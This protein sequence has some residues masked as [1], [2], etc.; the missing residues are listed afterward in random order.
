MNSKQLVNDKAGKPISG[1]ALLEVMIAIVIF[2]IG[3]IALAS[4]QGKLTRYASAAKQRTWAMNIAEDQIENMRAFVSLASI[5]TAACSVDPG[6]YEDLDDCG[7]AV[8]AA[9]GEL[10]YGVTWD[11][12]PYVMVD[13]PVVTGEAIIDETAANPD[14][15]LITVT[16]AW[17]DQAGDVQEVQL[18]DIIEATSAYNAA[19]LIADTDDSATPSVP[20]NP[21][22]FP[23]SVPIDLGSGLSK[24]TSTP[25]PR[26]TNDGVNVSTDFEVITYTNDGLTIDRREEFEV[27]NCICE[28]NSSASLG[29]EPTYW[30]GEQYQ[31]G[32]EVTKITGV[33]STESEGINLKQPFQCDVCC[34]DHHD[35]ASSTIKYDPWRNEAADSFGNHA[36]YN[37]VNGEFVLADSSSTTYLEACRLIRVDGF[38]QVATD[39]SLENFVV[40]PEDFLT[41][42]VEAYSS[43]ILNFASNFIDGVGNNISAY[44]GTTPAPVYNLGVPVPDVDF[45]DS[46]D[47]RQLSGRA[48]YID[49][50]QD[51]LLKKVLCLRSDGWDFSSFCDTGA[52][53]SWI[54]IM[55][56]FEL[57][58]TSLAT[59]GRTVTNIDVSNSPI[60]DAGKRKYSRG[61]ATVAEI[62]W[63]EVSQAIGEIEFSNTGLT[64]TNPIDSGDATTVED[65]QI[66]NV[67]VPAPPPPA[68]IIISGWIVPGSGSINQEA[69][70]LF[71]DPVGEDCALKTQKTGRRQYSCGMDTAATGTVA[72]G[73]VMI[74]DYN[75]LNLTTSP[76]GFITS[77]VLNR[78]ICTYSTGSFTT[79][80]TDN[81]VVA[82]PDLSIVG[83]TTTLGFT[84][85]AADVVIDL[86]VISEGD[87]C[88]A[89]LPKL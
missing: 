33:P 78:S 53:P 70:R 41:S 83:E 25:E 21:S 50:M 62:P 4:M 35:S 36:H 74:S 19:L 43:S 39:L 64:D 66:I 23:D 2:S 1:F 31:L 13:D 82:D 84:N 47:Q 51:D 75:G 89:T 22:D 69:V 80:V 14:F 58:T 26:I 11:V 15:K 28:L 67:T 24:L 65:D 85:L 12:T 46:T 18:S 45:G 71:V 32:A 61:L 49:F 54:D 20:F 9:L 7:T 87:A 73:T 34:R 16:V 60:T 8:T 30:D 88:P 3:L 17:T 27:V 77:V 86:L 5:G 81:G 63:I 38:M 48:I 42:N 44:P 10:T 40:M 72:A 59:W 37:I 6:S 52:D 79:T 29:R 76:D 55:P 68:R 57:N 56:F